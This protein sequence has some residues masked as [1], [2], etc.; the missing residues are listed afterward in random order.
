MA[1]AL[2]LFA[3]L[4]GL[5]PVRREGANRASRW[6][7]NLALYGLGFGVAWAVSPAILAFAGWVQ[8]IL[9]FP[10]LVEMGL[11]DWLLVVITFL[12]VDLVAYLTHVGFH[13]LPVLW[14][15]HRVHHADVFMD[16]STGVRHHPIEVLASVALQLI[17]FAILGLPLLVLM[18]YG[19]VSGIWQFFAHA[20]LRLP[21]TLDR[22]VC[23]VL[24]TP[25][26]HRVHHSV[27][28]EEGNSNFGMVLSIWDRLFGTY[29]RRP[30]SER[31]QM[32]LGIDEPGTRGGL[33]AMLVLP[34]R[35]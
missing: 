12:I 10:P 25:G 22:L 26:M 13:A 3:S 2:F 7:V 24:I 8:K 34:F 21:E 28:V 14:R 16:A 32:P 31:R 4:E 30:A 19:A 6:L 27:R 18:A 35:R 20:N 11:P 23:I 17:L 1:V 5:V 15:V 29:R 33:M 9:P